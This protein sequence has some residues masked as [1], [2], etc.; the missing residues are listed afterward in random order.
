M[1]GLGVVIVLSNAIASG[2]LLIRHS[3]DLSTIQ[4]QGRKIQKQGKTI[5]SIEGK[6]STENQN[7]IAA[8]KEQEQFAAWIVL[9]YDTNCGNQALIGAALG[10]TILKPCVPVPDFAPLPGT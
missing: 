8:G 6:V 1:V 5:I 3:G 7:L 4:D 10:I 9:G 2:Y